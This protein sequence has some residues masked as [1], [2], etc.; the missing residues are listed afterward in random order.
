MAKKITTKQIKDIISANNGDNP[1]VQSVF[2]Q[3]SNGQNVAITV[4]HLLSL[5]EMTALVDKV[6]DT[7]F[8]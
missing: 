3:D 6:V 4:K 8:I 5:S 2:V 7:C 1:K